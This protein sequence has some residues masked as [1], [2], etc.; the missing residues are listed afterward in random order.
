[1]KKQRLKALYFTVL[2]RAILF[3]FNYVGAYL[4]FWCMCMCTHTHPELKD[5]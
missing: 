4:R 3:I 1:M 5:V 2:T